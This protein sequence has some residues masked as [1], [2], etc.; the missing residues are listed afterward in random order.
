[1]APIDV[2]IL[3]LVAAAFVA[4]VVRVRRHG[5]CGD[6]ASSGSCPSCGSSKS[7]RTLFGRRSAKATCPA[8]EGVDAVAERLGRGVK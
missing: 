5:S 3:L 6:C 7:R 4:V 8:C 2:V 1:M